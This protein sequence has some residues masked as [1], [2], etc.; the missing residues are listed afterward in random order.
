MTDYV[1]MEFRVKIA[2]NPELDPILDGISRS[3]EANRTDGYA[4]DHAA[5]IVAEADSVAIEFGKFAVDTWVDIAMHNAGAEDADITL[6]DETGDHTFPI[7]AD[8]VLVVRHYN[9]STPG[10]PTVASTLGT[11]VELFMWGEPYVTPA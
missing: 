6:S 3:Y 11:T 1:K 4:R 10:A 7:E 2:S 9:N 8:Q 5:L